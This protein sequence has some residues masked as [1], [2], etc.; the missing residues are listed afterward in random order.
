MLCL[1]SCKQTSFLLQL[2]GPVGAE[3]RLSGGAQALLLANQ[4]GKRGYSLETP[5]GTMSVAPEVPDTPAL[6]AAARP[7]CQTEQ[8]HMC[9]LVAALFT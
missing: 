7:R 5:F 1:S 6:L 8:Q 2:S 4:K 3:E 9:L